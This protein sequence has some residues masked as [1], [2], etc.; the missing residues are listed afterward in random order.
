MQKARR[1]SRQGRRVSL[2]EAIPDFPMLKKRK[3]VQKVYTQGYALCCTCYLFIIYYLCFILF[4]S[5]FHAYSLA[6][7]YQHS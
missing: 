4:S 5:L 3:A 1:N 2:V 7:L 6:C